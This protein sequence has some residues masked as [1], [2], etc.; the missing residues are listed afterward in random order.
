[1]IGAVGQF[2][3]VVAGLGQQHVDRFAAHAQVGLDPFG[4]FLAAGQHGN[5]GQAGGHAEFVQRIQVERIAG[6]HHKRAIGSADREEGLAM[7]E[8]RGEVLQQAQIHLGFRQIDELQ[9]DLLAQ[10]PQ[11]RFLGEESQLDRRLIEAHA[12]RLGSRGPAP[13]VAGR[14]ALFAAV[15]RPRPRA[16]LSLRWKGLRCVTKSHRD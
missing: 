15:F 10:G 7:D 16:V 14:E 5:D 12:L 2:D 9:P 8:L 6:G 3:A 13:T 1:M 11:G 4:D